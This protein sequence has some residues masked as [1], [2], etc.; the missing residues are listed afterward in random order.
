[1]GTSDTIG[2]GEAAGPDHAGSVAIAWQGEMELQDA[3][4]SLG[5]GRSVEFRL[6]E[7]PDDPAHEHPFRHWQRKRGGRLGQR[8]H[9]VFVATDMTDAAYDGEVM[10]QAWTDSDRGRSV[11]F[12]L[13]EESHTHNFAGFNKRTSKEPGSMF[14]AV[15]VLLQDDGSVLDEKREEAVTDKRKKFSSQAHLMVTSPLFI[16]YL[17]ERCG[18]TQVLERKGLS[19]TP[20]RAKQYVKTKLGIESLSDLDRD[21][22]ALA[23]FHEQIRKPYSRF[24]GADR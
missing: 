11:K 16:Q 22:V 8:F 6:V 5:S 18:H 3:S 24:T 19:W 12:W 14:A 20:D 2:T 17:I 15:L 4:W 1:M 9:G 23:K 7:R 21:E 13:D 10:L